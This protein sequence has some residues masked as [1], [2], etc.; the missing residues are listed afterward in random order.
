MHSCRRLAVDLHHH[1]TLTKT[2]GRSVAGAILSAAATAPGPL[3]SNPAGSGTL[4]LRRG[5]QA[6]RLLHIP[7]CEAS[8]C[9]IGLGWG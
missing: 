8:G 3:D 9:S 7:Q 1:R 2:Y 4:S 5:K 6:R